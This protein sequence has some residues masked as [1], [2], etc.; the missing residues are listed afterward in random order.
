MDEHIYP[1]EAGFE[2]EVAHGDRS[3]PLALIEKLKDK[4]RAQ[5]LWNLFLPRDHHEAGLSNYEYAPLAEIMGRVE[6]AAEILCSRITRRQAAVMPW[7]S[8]AR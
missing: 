7:A 1:S 3:Q 6:W 8:P 5:G 4:A 2:Q